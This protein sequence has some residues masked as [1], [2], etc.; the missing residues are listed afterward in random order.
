VF[1]QVS[2]SREFVQYPSDASLRRV[3]GVGICLDA[4]RK[5]KCPSYRLVEPMKNLYA[6]VFGRYFLVGFGYPCCEVDGV[7]VLAAEGRVLDE[8]ER[9]RSEP[10]HV[11]CEVVFFEEVLWGIEY[12][13]V[14]TAGSVLAGQSVTLGCLSCSHA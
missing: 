5:R 10:T 9:R 2:R 1:V 8:L 13:V 3:D 7:C 4:R 14:P 12:L 11:F 6:A